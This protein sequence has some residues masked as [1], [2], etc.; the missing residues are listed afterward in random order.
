MPS[1]TARYGALVQGGHDV[2]FSRLTAK[3]P[4]GMDPASKERRK[5][6]FKSADVNGNGY[7]SQ[8]EVDKAVGEAIGSEDLFSAKPVIGRAFA[9]AK[10]LGGGNNADY[11]EKSEFR[12]LLVY[13][14]QY[15]ELYVAYNRLDSSDDRRLSLPE[16][17]SGVELLSTWGIDIPEGEV[18][19]EFRRI[20]TNGGGV[21]LFDEFSDWALKK[22]LDLEDDDDWIDDDPPTGGAAKPTA[23]TGKRKAL[24]VGIN[25]FGKGEAELDG[26]VADAERV[27]AFLVARGFHDTP[28][29]MR[30]L[31][32]TSPT[33]GLM[34]TRANILRGIEWLVKDAAA[35][36]VLFFHFSGHG[37]QQVDVSGDEADGLDECIVPSDHE[38]S[39]LLTDDQLFDRLV[40]PLPAG[41]RLTALMDCCGSGTGLD[42]PFSAVAGASGWST[43]EGALSTAAADVRL[44]SASP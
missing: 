26:C 32:D 11:V 43:E 27:K 9:A 31:A 40:R 21:I 30:V 29:S 7:L 20:D 19:A 24:L 23:I 44:L 33:M 3:L 34:P 39:G 1:N 14:R 4:T 36:D 12:L 5:K 18:E 8:A 6:L 25:Y 15:F 13:L 41:C 22:Q 16:F 37:T 42:L 35:G 10:N 2:D 38:T 28:R 17:R